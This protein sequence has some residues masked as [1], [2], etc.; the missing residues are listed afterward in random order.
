M[1][2]IYLNDFLYILNDV[3][4]CNN[5]DDKTPNLCDSSL[6]VV[7]E[8]LEKISQFTKKWFSHNYMKL[9]AENNNF[10]VTGHRFDY[11]WLNFYESQVS[12]KK[13]GQVTWYSNQQ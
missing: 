9:N 3:D 6:K 1:F 10:L 8:R 2:N 4:I 7:I 12:E 13:P 11:L 5:A